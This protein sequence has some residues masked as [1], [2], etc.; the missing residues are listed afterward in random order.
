MLIC[1]TSTCEWLPLWLSWLRIRLQYGKPGFNPWVGKMPWRRKRLPTPVFWPGE[2]HGLYSPQGHKESDTA[3]RLSLSTCEWKIPK[4]LGVF[5]YRCIG[6][7]FLRRPT[8]VFHVFPPEQERMSL[9]TCPCSSY[10][11]K[12]STELFVA[13]VLMLISL[14]CNLSFPNCVIIV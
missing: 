6:L 9:N 12:L 2:F 4:S 3:E 8:V 14:L 5:I 11:W 1:V 10:P 13:A 7:F